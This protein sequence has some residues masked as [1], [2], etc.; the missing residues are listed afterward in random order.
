[1]WHV[2]G[3]RKM[4]TAFWWETVEERE[5]WEQ[6]GLEGMVYIVVVKDIG[7]GMEW[8]DLRSWLFWDF[9]FQFPCII[10]LY[11]IK[12]Q[13]DATLAVL[14]ISNC[15]ISLHVSDVSAFIIRSTKNCSSSHWC[16][17]W[18]GMIYIQ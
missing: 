16:I 11:Y 5:H 6:I 2:L 3:T 14:F 4:C 17:S 12:N 7:W 9:M 1:M 8:N 15:K 13:Q 10:S 18:V